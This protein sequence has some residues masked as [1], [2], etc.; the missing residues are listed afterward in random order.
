MTNYKEILR[1]HS[2]QIS[3]RDI[4]TNLGISR[5]TV[6]SVISRATS[7]GLRWP[8]DVQMSDTDIQKLLFPRGEDLEERKVPDYDFVHKQLQKDGMEKTDFIEPSVRNLRATCTVMR[9]R[10]TNFL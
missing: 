8:F 4:S 7:I 2:H 10:R 5:N 3:Q 1:L 6:S 9:A